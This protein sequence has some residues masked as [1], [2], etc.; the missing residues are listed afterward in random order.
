[1]LLNALYKSLFITIDLIPNISSIILFIIEN[2][3]K[4]FFY[5][6]FHLE[7]IQ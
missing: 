7:S 4:P 1:M 6:M 3:Q 5:Q 2:H